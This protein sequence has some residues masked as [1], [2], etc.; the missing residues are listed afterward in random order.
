MATSES[1]AKPQR[2]VPP[3]TQPWHENVHLYNRKV[4]QGLFYFRRKKLLLKDFFK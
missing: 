4:S 3:W 1:K 2:H